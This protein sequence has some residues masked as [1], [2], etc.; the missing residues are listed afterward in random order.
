VRF[1]SLVLF[2]LFSALVAACTETPS[3][4]PPC[5]DPAHPCAE[6]D[7]GSDAG[8]EAGDATPA[9]DAADAAPAQ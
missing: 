7:G 2:P 5:V 6:D 4:I 9:P 3:Y 1:G 8:L